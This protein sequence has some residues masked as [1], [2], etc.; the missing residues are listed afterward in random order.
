ALEA[1]TLLRTVMSEIDVAVF[2]FDDNN[3]LR[4]AN[5]A[6]VRLLGRLIERLVESTAAKVGLADSLSGES[7]R[8][9]EA[10]FPGGVG[11]WGL[12]RTTSDKLASPTN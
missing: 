1:T 4:L 10:A 5:C 6:A 8:T 2:A 7:V 12:R 9:F 11:L 3:R